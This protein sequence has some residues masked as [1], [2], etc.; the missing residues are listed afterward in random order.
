MVD[1][2]AIK[3]ATKE[4]IDDIFSKYKPVKKMGD[5]DER[6]DVAIIFDA[7]IDFLQDY[8]NRLETSLDVMMTQLKKA[9]GGG[10]WKRNN[11]SK[12]KGGKKGGKNN[13][14]KKRH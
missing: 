9:N 6:G 10:N 11:K 2:Q 1:L 5:G 7:A 14:S 13:K 3:N 12:K 8:P 4:E